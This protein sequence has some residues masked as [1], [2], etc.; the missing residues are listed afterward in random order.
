ME[1]HPLAHRNHS[2]ILVTVRKN[3]RYFKNYLLLKII[4][5]EWW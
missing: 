3:G 1:K 4:Y 2:I 5:Q